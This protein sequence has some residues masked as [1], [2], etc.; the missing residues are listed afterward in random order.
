MLRWLLQLFASFAGRGSAVRKPVVEEIEPRILYSADVNPL[1]WGGVDPNATAI[2][3]GIDSGSSSAAPQTVD[4][5]Q[6]Q[7]RRMTPL[8]HV[9]P[10]TAHKNMYDIFCRGRCFNNTFQLA[11]L[12][13]W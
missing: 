2:V 10:E 9:Q 11:L 12:N 1:L 8:Q 4:A 7:Q 13:N 6:Q 3:A 5:Q